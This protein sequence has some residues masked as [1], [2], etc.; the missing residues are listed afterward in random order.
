MKIIRKYKFR[1]FYRA[2]I[3]LCLLLSSCSISAEE[4]RKVYVDIPT[5]PLIQAVIEF[6]LQTDVSIVAQEAHLIGYVATPII[7]NF[8]VGSALSLIIAQAPVTVSYLADRDTYLIQPKLQQLSVGV[9]FQPQIKPVISEETIIVGESIPTRYPLS[10][11]SLDRNGISHF[12][13]SRFHNIA[14]KNFINDLEPESLIALLEYSSGAT[15]AHGL[16]GTNDDY[17]IR[18][19]RRK[20]LYVDGFRLSDRT[21]MQLT[22]ALLDKVEVLKGP[23]MLFYGQSGAGGVVNV[24]RSTTGNENTASFNTTVG[25]DDYAETVIDV[26]SKS[27]FGGLAPMRLVGVHE[28]RGLGGLYDR[29]VRK[30]IMATVELKPHDKFS[31]LLSYHWQDYKHDNE[32]ERFAISSDGNFLPFSDKEF[33][34]HSGN[35]SFAASIGLLNASFHYFPA[36]KWRLSGNYLWQEEQR[37]GLR[38]DE[39]LFLDRDVLLSRPLDSDRVGISHIANRLAASTVRTDCANESCSVVPEIMVLEDQGEYETDVSLNVYLTGTFST[40]GFEHRSI[41]GLDSYHQDLYQLF[42]LKQYRPLDP[43]SWSTGENTKE[44]GL[45]DIWLS[46]EGSDAVS[47]SRL[48]EYRVLRD[49]YGLYAQLHTRWNSA[50]MTSFGGRLSKFIGEQRSIT[51]DAIGLVGNVSDISPQFGIVFQPIDELSFFSN[52]SESIAVRYLIDDLGNFSQD[53][54]V[55]QQWELGL[56]KLGFGDSLAWSV[57][58]FDIKKSH[59]YNL[60]VEGGVRKLQGP[61]Q[62]NVTGLEFDVSYGFGDYWQVLSHLTLL[63]NRIVGVGETHAASHVPDITWSIF[64]HWDFSYSWDATLGIYGVSDRSLDPQELSKLDAYQ[65]VD[66]SLS[67]VFTIT[68]YDLSIKL[69]LKNLF[70][71]NLYRAANLGAYADRSSGR[72]AYIKFG[73]QI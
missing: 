19:Y 57:A 32:D 72:S 40:Y 48:K 45:Y 16:G 59:V 44:V 69:I 55:A 7:G 42:T 9:D 54:E 12:D 6:A 4:F 36:P 20:S 5:Q 29:Q 49:D 8:H 13:S 62:H 50:W 73:F 63:K 52:Y 66:A 2:I 34:G 46:R 17:H 53:P 71:E 23:S 22:S 15:K 67:R 58:L 14:G 18:G 10:I 1:K 30:D 27:L 31:T 56:K 70:N 38:T 64:N 39:N 37:L 60:E 68:Q 3:A 51:D 11:N 25:V 28:Y 41:L 47:N 43:L 35:P 65:S 24:I 21:A 26:N 33:F 61:F